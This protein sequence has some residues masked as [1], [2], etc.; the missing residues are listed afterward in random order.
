MLV[1]AQGGVHVPTVVVAGRAGPRAALLVQRPIAGDRARR[2]R[3]RRRHRRAARDALWRD[4]DALGRGRIVHGDLD[5][6]HVIVSRRT[7]RGSWGSTTPRS[8]AIPTDH[9]ADVAELLASTA[10][11]VGDERAV[12]AAVD[13]VGP[14]GGGA[15]AAAPA[16]GRAVVDAPASSS[17][18]RPTAVRRPARPLARRAAASRHRHRAARAGADPAHHADRRG[19]GARRAGRG[20]CVAARRRRPGRRRRHD[21]QRQLGLDR[22][23]RSWSRSRP[24]SRTPSRC[25]ARCAVPLAARADHRAAGRRCRSRT[26]RSRR[27]AVRACRCASCRSSG[28]DLPSAVAAGGVLSGFGGARR[29]VRLLRGRAARRTGARRP[30][31]HPDQRPA[32]APASWSRR[33]LVL[34]ERRW[35]PSLPTPARARAAAAVA[36]DAHDGRRAALTAAPR[37]ADRR[38]RRRRRSCRPGVCSC[39]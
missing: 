15:G 29:R 2:P 23:R 27:S 18:E 6:D 19:D 38:Q 9:A 37:A 12:R 11:L 17:G 39:A 36:R 32:A 28:V 21:A 1:A 31:A 25:R 10:A 8:P 4:V 30:V 22:A 34:V 5:A 14:A 26:S 33:S 16:T 7:S 20:R 13:G 24:T 3:P 35:S